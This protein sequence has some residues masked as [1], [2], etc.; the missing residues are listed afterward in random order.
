MSRNL[1]PNSLC[2]EGDV[3][4]VDQQQPIVS[5]AE[6]VEAGI[7]IGYIRWCHQCNKY[8]HIEYSKTYL[9]IHDTS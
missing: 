6:V 1:T 3:E 4:N 7:K 2:T 9:E 8:H 5:A